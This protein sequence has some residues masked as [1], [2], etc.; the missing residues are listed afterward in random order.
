MQLTAATNVRPDVDALLT[1]VRRRRDERLAYARLILRPD[2]ARPMEERDAELASIRMGLRT[3]DG[4]IAD[5]LD[6]LEVAL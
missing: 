5:A 4:L 1:L 6:A 3:L 2:H